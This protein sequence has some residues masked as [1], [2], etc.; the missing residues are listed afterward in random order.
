MFVLSD[1]DLGLKDP[2]LRGWSGELQCRIDSSR[3][4]GR[5]DG[6]VVSIGHDHDSCPDRRNV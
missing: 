4:G 6:S 5:L 2:R 1:A 3:Y